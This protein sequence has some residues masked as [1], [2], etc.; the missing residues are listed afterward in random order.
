V[1]PFDRLDPGQAA[2][3]QL[4]MPVRLLRQIISMLLVAAYLSAMIFVTAPTASAAPSEM[5]GG[6][7]MQHGANDQ[8]PMPCKGMKA[9][10]VTELG[11]VFMVSLPAPDLTLTTAIDWFAYRTWAFCRRSSRNMKGL[12]LASGSSASGGLLAGVMTSTTPGWLLAARTSRK[13]TRP[14]AMLLTAAAT[15]LA[16]PVDSLTVSDGVI[17]S[18][19]S[20][21]KL[22]FGEVALDA[23]NLDIPKDVKVKDAKTFKIVGKKTDRVDNADI[24]TGKATYG[25]D[26][27]VPGMLFAVVKRSP[28]FGGKVVSVDDTKAKAI[29]GVRSKRYSMPSW[30]VP[31]SR[32]RAATASSPITMA[33]EV[34]ANAITSIRSP[35]RMRR[36]ACAMSFSISRSVSGVIDAEFMI[37]LS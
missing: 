7:R 34:Q 33:P 27:R 6:M 35:G 5:S 37:R 20:G 26:V 3:Y 31:A 30:P 15:R 22:T 32:I 29:P 18:A 23:G 17:I 25:I 10:C 11:C 13:V 24:V 9:G 19:T 36:V 12:V 16:V 8:M 14:R 4:R 2:T 21:K 28:V 1:L